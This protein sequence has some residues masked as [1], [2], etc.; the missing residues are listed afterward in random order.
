MFVVGLKS[1]AHQSSYY[2]NVAT[3]YVSVVSQAR[4]I[5]IMLLLLTDST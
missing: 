4:N 5:I 3:A 1:P 2:N